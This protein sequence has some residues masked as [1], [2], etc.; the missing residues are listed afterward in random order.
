[1]TRQST[2]SRRRFVQTTAASS[3]ALAGIGLGRP[4]SAQSAKPNIVFIMADD[5]GY[6]DVSCYGQRDYRTPNI[7]GLAIGGLRF[8]QGYANSP[9]CSATRVALITGRYQYRLAVGLEEP[10]SALSPRNAGL[11]P[12]HP[13]LP[14]LLK[15][16]GYGTALVGKWHL[17]SLPDFS[18]LKSGY[19]QFFGI[20]G[21]AADYFNHGADAL[22]AYPLPVPGVAGQL[23]EQEVPVERHGYLT[24]LLGDRA[25]QT[26]EAYAR[27]REPFL[28]SLHFTAPHWPWEGPDDEAES[29]RIRSIFHR[30]GGTQRTYAA[31]VQSLDA[32]IGRVLQALDASGLAGNTIVVFTSDNGG[33]RFSNTWPF[34]G[35][36]EELLEG[37]LRIPSIVR[38]PGRIAAGSVSEQ[39][40]ATMDWVPTLLAAAGTSPDPDYPSDGEDLGPIVTGRTAP[41]P[42]KL[43]WQYKA[44]AQCAVRDGDW[45]YLRIAGNEFLFD[46]VQDPRERANLKDRQKDVFDRLKGDWEAWN[47]TMLPERSRPAMFGNAGNFLA[48]RYGVT[49]PAPAGP[50]ASLPKE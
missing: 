26:I 14:S 40:M 35:M 20:F 9:V 22:K 38:W 5:L 45:K 39:V 47:A 23:Y 24:N 6:A 48:D 8:T 37:G 10:I 2:I 16:A 29:M 42:R 46:V 33:E 11:P 13:T 15:K 44:G 41:Q 21:G 28:L 36:K 50:S 31:M 49:N 43:H 12:S 18:P 25:V 34:T 19:D 17:G 3:L 32:D 7:D 1:M 27:S 30:D 4:G